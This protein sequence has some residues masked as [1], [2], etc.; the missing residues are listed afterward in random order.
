[1]RLCGDKKCDNCGNKKLFEP[2]ENDPVY[3][4][5]KD[6]VW[7]GEIESL[8]TENNIPYLKQGLFGAG[9]TISMGHA[10]E[11]YQIYVPFGAY[12]KAKKLLADIFADEN[13]GSEEIQRK[14]FD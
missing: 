7:S 12:E 5:T 11:T 2:K 3:L 1:M 4:I 13:S 8:F 14:N 10:M 6:F 9:I